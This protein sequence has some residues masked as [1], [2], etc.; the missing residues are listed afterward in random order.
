MWKKQ[1][2]EREQPP[3]KK[4]KQTNKQK[5]K[6]KYRLFFKISL[7]MAYTATAWRPNTVV[8]QKQTGID[9]LERKNRVFFFSVT[10]KI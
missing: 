6:H 4:K 9:Y 8:A 1:E 5:K 10:V 3:Q 2:R 7:E